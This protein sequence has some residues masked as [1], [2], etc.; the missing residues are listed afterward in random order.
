MGREHL[1]SANSRFW[2]RERTP[3]VPARAIVQ[4]RDLEM[5]SDCCCE[6]GEGG[7]EE[8][9]CLL[10]FCSFCKHPPLASLG[11]RFPGKTDL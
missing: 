1:S 7:L 3:R 5:Q 2:K 10:F 9:D 4:W 8:K 11:D 6:L